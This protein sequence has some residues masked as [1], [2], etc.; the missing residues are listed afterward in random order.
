MQ[1]TNLWPGDVHGCP[2]HILDQ[3][4]TVFKDGT[5]LWGN[6]VPMGHVL[7]THIY[8]SYYS[9]VIH[10]RQMV[11]L[12]PLDHVSVHQQ[13]NFKGAPEVRFKLFELY[14]HSA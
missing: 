8:D 2:H 4:S 6:R 11:Q 7:K 13:L 3:N 10:I 9:S 5:N 14:V 1:G 12:M